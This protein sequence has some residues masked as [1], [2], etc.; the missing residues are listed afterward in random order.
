MKRLFCF[1]VATVFVAGSAVYAQEVD[2]TVQMQTLTS[3]DDVTNEEDVDF[4]PT[5]SLDTRFGYERIVSGESAGFGGDGLFLNIDGR[6]SKRFSYSFTHRLFTSNGEDSSVFDATDILTLNYEVGGWKF[7]AGKDYIILGNWEY[8]AYDLDAYFDMNTYFYNSFSGQQWGIMAAWT[9]PSKTSTFMFQA[10][11]SPYADEPKISNLY[12]FGLGWQGSWDWYESY[13]TVNMWE[14]S[15]GCYVKNIAL[16]NIFYINDLSITADFMMRGVEFDEFGD[17]I[18][19]T[20]QPAYNIC[21]KVRL[22][23]KFGWEK[24]DHDG[25]FDV[26]GGMSNSDMIAANEECGTV[27]PEYLVPGDDYIFY[28]AGVEYFPIKDNQNVRL[29]AVWASNNYTERHMLNIGLTWKFDIVN[30]ISR[31]VKR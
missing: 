26:V 31:I 10:T 19:L 4:V 24:G 21:D 23:G 12:A 28:G 2:S 1:L 14:Y 27:L 8:D 29:H 7:S 6:I 5:I 30:A 9:N 22:F 25:M 16:G 15:N 13:W 3:Q 18:S 20:I 11:N 17:N